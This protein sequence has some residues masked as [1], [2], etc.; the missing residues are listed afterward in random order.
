MRA[1]N[2]IT[3]VAEDGS[4]ADYLRYLLDRIIE[5]S[6]RSETVFF[7]PFFESN[8][9]ATE[10]VTDYGPHG[11]HFTNQVNFDEAPIIRGSI[12]RY[13]LNGGN[14]YLQHPDNDVFSMGADGTVPNEP[15]ITWFCAGYMHA[16]TS[17]MIMS[18]SDETNLATEMEWKFELTGGR[19]LRLRIFDDSAGARIGQFSTPLI[20]N[21]G[22][23]TLGAT[24]DATRVDA[25]VT[26]YIDGLG[27]ASTAD[28]AGAYTAME[29][30]AVITALGTYENNAGVLANFYD[31]YMA[32]P[33]MT[34]KNLSAAQMG[35]LDALY[36]RLLGI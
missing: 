26:L 2:Q 31:G 35:G 30:T 27:V 16:A 17:S 22:W 18:R 29:N 19:N 3:T 9:A 5:I 13:H 36:R 8:P 14:E 11:L 7:L 25:G 15:V 28:G 20:A 1:L 23:V 10:A 32:L 34:N 6:G 21:N 33:L 12:L 4:E 24:Y